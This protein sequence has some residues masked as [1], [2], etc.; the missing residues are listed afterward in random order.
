[1]VDVGG[2]LDVQAHGGDGVTSAELIAI[3]DRFRDVEF[4]KDLETRRAEHGD[5]AEQHPLPRTGQQRAFDAVVSIFRTANAAEHPGAASESLVH[6]VIDAHSWSDVLANAGL[7]PDDLSGLDPE[8]IPTLV[9]GEVPLKDRRCETSTGIQLHPHD[10]LRAALAGHV[11]RVV[12]DSAGVVIG[13]GRRQRLFTGAAREAAKLLIRRCEHPGCDLPA[14]WCHVDHMTEWADGGP[15]DQT[16]AGVRC[17]RHNTTKTVK[18]WRT[19]RDVNGRT[20]TIREDG[21]I[22]IPVGMRPPVFPDEDPDEHTPDE[23]AHLEQ[24][25]RNRLEALRTA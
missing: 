12:V 8:L 18:R 4:Q 10:V 25:A 23:I 6:I 20:H 2:A 7:T 15:T 5:A 21:T 22:I 17:G 19:K 13:L 11:R 1:M 24:L 16:N 14:D 3:F 9:S